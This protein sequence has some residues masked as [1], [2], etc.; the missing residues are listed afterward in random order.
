MIP[1]S[2]TDRRRAFS[3]WLRTGRLP[4][5]AIAYGVE[6]KFNPW[7]DPAD[8]RF[9]F[10]GSG[11]NYGQSGSGG[12]RGGGG[13]RAAVAVLRRAR[14]GLAVL[15]QTAIGSGYA[16]LPLPRQRLRP[17]DLHRLKRAPNGQSRKMAGAAE[18]LREVGAAASAVRGRREIGVLIRQS[19]GRCRQLPPLPPKTSNHLCRQQG[20]P[21]IPR[22]R[23]R[24]VAKCAMATNIRSTRRDEPAECPAL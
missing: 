24:F 18:A 7:H 17:L 3:I 1:I 16:Q 12:F 19:N 11:Q 13:D 21:S 23:H 22:Q 2:D 14:R 6:L 8:G 20:R 10:A 9:T 5:V 4:S 15:D